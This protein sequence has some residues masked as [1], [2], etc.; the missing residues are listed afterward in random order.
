[1]VWVTAWNLHSQ[2]PITA[3]LK[4]LKSPGRCA[5]WEYSVG[6]MLKWIFL[7]EPVLLLWVDTW[8]RELNWV[9]LSTH[10]Y[11]FIA[12]VILFL[13]LDV[14][15]VYIVFSVSIAELL[16]CER[17]PAMKASNC[18]RIIWRKI[19]ILTILFYILWERKSHEFQVK[20]KSS[21]RRKLIVISPFFSPLCTDKQGRRV[22]SGLVSLVLKDSFQVLRRLWK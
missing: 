7:D 20:I 19:T 3:H 11:S 18:F 17:S 10:F 15:S 4:T 5:A 16:K 2:E 1:M 13:L 22:A 21:S 9:Q 12:L 6:Q 14:I 8:V